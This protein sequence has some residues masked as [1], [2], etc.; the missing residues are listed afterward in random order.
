MHHEVLQSIYFF[1]ATLALSPSRLSGTEVAYIDRN[2]RFYQVFNFSRGAGLM[3]SLYTSHSDSPDLLV[4]A[5][6]HKA[7]LKKHRPKT[8]GRVVDDSFIVLD[9]ALDEEPISIQ[10][11]D[12]LH[13]H[14]APNYAAEQ[15]D[16]RFRINWRSIF[17]QIF[18]E[19]TKS[20][21]QRMD[22]SAPTKTMTELLEMISSFIYLGKQA[23]S[24]A[25]S[26]L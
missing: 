11:V 26:S 13:L 22:I 23:K 7:A 9:G 8:H 3:M 1:R 24:I 20:S 16:T 4:T 14:D 15:G 21:T 5:P 18:V 17:R 10:G 25:M 12:Q 6:N 19:E 2:I